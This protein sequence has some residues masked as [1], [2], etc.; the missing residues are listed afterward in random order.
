M[1]ASQK[2]KKHHPERRLQFPKLYHDS[3]GNHCD[4]KSLKGITV[5]AGAKF[6]S[7]MALS[8]GQTNR[9]FRDFAPV[10]GYVDVWSDMLG[11]KFYCNDSVLDNISSD[12]TTVLPR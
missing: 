4:I 5:K 10:R 12:P 2:V 6:L 1:P 8:N 11:A 7:L 9:I 3:K